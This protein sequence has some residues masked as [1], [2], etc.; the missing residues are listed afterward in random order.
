MKA[1][2]EMDGST[3]IVTRMRDLAF[4]VFRHLYYMSN[5]K[6]VKDRRWI[7]SERDFSLPAGRYWIGDPC[8][9]QLDHVRKVYLGL[10]EECE[11]KFTV[12]GVTFGV[13][14]TKHG[15]GSYPWKVVESTRRGTVVHHTDNVPT[16][17]ASLIPVDSGR[18]GIIPFDSLP[19]GTDYGTGI[20]VTFDHEFVCCIDNDGED[21]NFGGIVVMTNPKED[22][23]DADA[24][25]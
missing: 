14:P 8:Y 6:I 1:L 11:G 19:W 13:F 25:C 10:S 22:Y 18:I 20:V 3:Y 17:P 7:D 9:V 24:G 15:D 12:D 5:P 21:L 16:L 4:E 23:E 2:P